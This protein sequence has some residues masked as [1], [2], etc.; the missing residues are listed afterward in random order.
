MALFLTHLRRNVVA[1]LA[2][3]VAM[4][5]TSYAA[6]A[7]ANGSITTAKLH[8]NAVTSKKIKNGTVKPK[9][10]KKPTYV[11]S[12]TLGAGTPAAVPDV[13]SVAPYDFSVPHKGRT[14]VTV[15]I[16][17]LSGS[18]GGGSSDQPNVGLYIDN[19]PVPGTGAVVPGAAGA[20]PFEL[21]ATLE[22]AAGAHA[23]R[24]GIT[25]SGSSSPN[26]ASP[27]AE[28]WTILQAG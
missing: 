6:V 1:Y 15:F 8:T 14:S 13:I 22:L 3:L 12:V 18:C 5:G 28:S 7:V 10:L 16:P 9:D 11:Q 25:C 24:V 26:P 20:R 17:S 27:G 21:T 4:T 19:V 2:L 23:G